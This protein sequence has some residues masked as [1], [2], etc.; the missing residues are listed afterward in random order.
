V[1][2][3]WKEECGH[4][5]FLLVYVSGSSRIQEPHRV[6]FR[7]AALTL[8]ACFQMV[9]RSNIGRGIN[10]SEGFLGDFPQSL[11]LNALIL[12]SDGSYPS[13]AL[14]CKNSLFFA[15]RVTLYNL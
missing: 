6:R 12:V 13:I 9:P 15:F 2:L 7:V 3:I 1:R 14:F 5:F 4:F 8:L 10:C 11:H